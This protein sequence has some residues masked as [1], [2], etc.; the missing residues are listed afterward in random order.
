LQGLRKIT[1][2]TLDG[3]SIVP[4]EARSVNICSL[5][6]ADQHMHTCV[7]GSGRIPVS[8]VPKGI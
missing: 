4:C 1:C 8:A 3:V 7:V 5:E 6:R 2:A